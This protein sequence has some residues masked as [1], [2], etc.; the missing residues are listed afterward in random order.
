MARTGVERRDDAAPVRL[1]IFEVTLIRAES[2]ANRKTRRVQI[3][4]LTATAVDNAISL[5]PSLSLPRDP[6]EQREFL[7]LPLRMT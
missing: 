4:S 1:R 2:Q 3:Q 7:L 6:R 5:C